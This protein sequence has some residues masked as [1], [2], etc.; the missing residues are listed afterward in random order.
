MATM[1]QERMSEIAAQLQ[2][3]AS[4]RAK[5]AAITEVKDMLEIVHTADCDAFLRTLLPPICGLLASVPALVSPTGG[6]VPA[7]APAGP[8]AGGADASS[9]PDERYVGHWIR[10]L[11]LEILHRIPTSSE[12]LKL[13]IGDILRSCC[14]A[15]A[16]D[17]EVNGL[18]AVR[19]VF[20]LH[21]NFRPDDPSFA[22]QFLQWTAQAYREFHAAYTHHESIV[23]EGGAATARASRERAPTDLVA[24]AK[25]TRV[26]S[27]C[28]VIIMFFHQLYK[29]LQTPIRDSARIFL[30][31]VCLRVPA[32]QRPDA[33]PQSEHVAA[34]FKGVQV[35]TLSFLTF[36]LKQYPAMFAERHKDI[37]D[38]VVYMLETCPDSIQVRKE[39]LIA[40]RHIVN[41][42]GSPGLHAS[43]FPHVATLMKE[44]TLL[45]CFAKELPHATSSGL[46]PLAYSLLAEI[47]HYM[48]E[49][50]TFDMIVANICLFEG[51]VHT[52][53]MTISI[54][55]TCIR[56]LLN[57]VQTLFHLRQPGATDPEAQRR[58]TRGREL[59][60]SVFKCYLGRMSALAQRTPALLDEARKER[61]VGGAI[62]ARLQKD[63]E[64][65]VKPWVLKRKPAGAGPAGG[66]GDGAGPGSTTDVKMDEGG[67]AGPEQ[68][69]APAQAA[70]EAC[71][72]T[73]GDAAPPA[74]RA[75]TDEGPAEAPPAADDAGSAPAQAPDPQLA[76][77]E[78]APYTYDVT[79]EPLHLHMQPPSDRLRELKDSK[80][81]LNVLMQSSRTIVFVLLHYETPK[82]APGAAPEPPGPRDPARDRAL[83]HMLRRLLRLA[84]KSFPLMWES[85]PQVSASQLHDR[86]V[87][88]VSVLP[89]QHFLDVFSGIA[90]DLFDAFMSCDRALHLALQLATHEQ[91]DVC[92]SFADIF[93]GYLL[94]NKLDKLGGGEGKDADKTRA[95][96]KPDDAPAA[97]GE[98]GPERDGN[99]GNRD[100]EPANK[101]QDDSDAARKP[102][103]ARPAPTESERVLRLFHLMFGAMKH[104]GGLIH[105]VLVPRLPMLVRAC[106]AAI[107]HHPDPSGHLELLRSCFK[108]LQPRPYE[109]V[110]AVLE[111]MLPE[112]IGTF[113]LMLDTPP[114][115]FSREQIVELML[116]IPVPLATLVPYLGTLVRPLMAALKS[117]EDG[118]LTQGLKALELWIDNVNPDYLDPQMVP[119]HAELVTTLHQML[120]PGQVNFS[121][122]A[123][124]ILGKLGGRNRR[125]CG[126]PY[127]L[128]YRKYP[129]HGLRLILCLEPQTSFLFPLDRCMHLA[130]QAITKAP[131]P[132]TSPRIPGRSAHQR[133][134]AARF[135]RACMARVLNLQDPAE[136]SLPGEPVDK[137]RDAL[138]GDF[139]APQLPDGI[140][141]SNMGVKTK[142]Q[143]GAEMNTVLQALAALLIAAAD[144]ELRDET[145]PFLRG[146]AR[147]VAL[148]FVSC[149]VHDKQG[150]GFRNDPRVAEEP[151]QAVIRLCEI[152]PSI[153]LEALAVQLGSADKAR[154][155]VALECVDVF[156]ASLLTFQAATKEH[157]LPKEAG[158][159]EGDAQGGDPMDVDATSPADKSAKAP[160]GGGGASSGA[161]AV[162]PS[163]H[164]FGPAL[165]CLL[166]EINK[167]LH[168]SEP[169]VLMGGVDALSVVCSHALPRHVL[170]EWVCRTLRALFGAIEHLPSIATAE[171][172]AVRATVRRWLGVCIGARV[173]EWRPVSAIVREA[174]R[175]AGTAY[176]VLGFATSAVGEAYAGDDAATPDEQTM[177]VDGG[178]V[179]SPGDAAGAPAEVD[180]PANVQEELMKTL[181]FVCLPRN[182]MRALYSQHVQL[183]GMEALTGLAAALGTTVQDL[184]GRTQTGQPARSKDAGDKDGGRAD[185]RSLHD[186][187]GSILNRLVG[188]GLLAQ[189]GRV[190]SVW[191]C[192]EVSPMLLGAEQATPLLHFLSEVL[193]LLEAPDSLH[194]QREDL[195]FTQA[196]L[197]DGPITQLRAACLR[198]L[199]PLLEKISEPELAPLRAALQSPAPPP[200]APPAQHL[201]SRD[202]AARPLDQ[203]I[204]ITLLHHLSS[205]KPLEAAA[206]RTAVRH[207]NKLGLGRDSM[208]HALEL[209]LNP[210]G[211]HRTLSLPLLRGMAH[212]LEVFP[213]WF[214][215]KLG[216]KLLDHLEKWMHPEKL[217]D[218]PHARGPVQDP[219][220]QQVP[221]KAW[222]TG[223]ETAVGVALVDLFHRLPGEQAAALLQSA[224]SRCGLVV[225]LIQVEQALNRQGLHIPSEEPSPYRRPLI[226]FLARHHKEALE[227][228]LNPRRLHDPT[229]FRLLVEIAR[230]PNGKGFLEHLAAHPKQLLVATGL[231]EA[232]PGD[233]ERGAGRASSSAHLDGSAAAAAAAGS[234]GVSGWSGPPGSKEQ[235]AQ[236]PGALLASAP[237]DM[238]PPSAAQLPVVRANGVRLITCIAQQK[239]GWLPAHP[240]VLAALMQRWEGADIQS[241]LVRSHDADLMGPG[242]VPSFLS[243]LTVQE[244]RGIAK[245]MVNVLR[246]R[247]ADPDGHV[248][249]LARL[250]HVVCPGSFAFV[251]T[252]VSE[253]IPGT[254]PVESL[255]QVVESFTATFRNVVAPLHAASARG[256]LPA[257]Q[258]EEYRQRELHMSIVLDKVV[259][260]IVHK[261]VERGVLDQ[262]FTDSCIQHLLSHVLAVDSADGAATP[263]SAA[264]Q[265]T[266]PVVP[267]APRSPSGADSYSDGLMVSLLELERLVMQHLG[268]RVYDYRKELIKLCWNHLKREDCLVKY[269]AFHTVAQFLAVID[270]PEKV[271]LQVF[272]ALLRAAQ[273][274]GRAYV[275]RATDVLLPRLRR[276][277]DRAVRER[278]ADGGPSESGGGDDATGARSGGERAAQYPMWVRWTKRIVLEEGH[279]LPSMIHVWQLVVRHSDLYY[280]AR[281][282]FSPM[283]VNSLS[284]LGLPTNSPIENRKLAID[285]AGVFIHWET[286]HRREVAAQRE[287]G[288]AEGEV[289]AK[290]FK[291]DVEA[292]M[293]SMVVNFLLRMCFLAMSDFVQR[294]EGKKEYQIMYHHTLALLTRALQLW[295]NTNV[296]MTYLE[297][298]L[299]NDLE[300]SYKDDD[301][302]AQVAP[303]QMAALDILLRLV[304]IAGAT[305][306]YA[307]AEQLAYLLRFTISNTR[308]EAVVDKLCDVLRLVFHHIDVPQL[309]Q[310]PQG[311][312][313]VKGIKEMLAV[314][315]Q[316]AQRTLEK[317]IHNTE[318][319]GIKAQLEANF[320]NC[321]NAVKVMEVLNDAHMESAQNILPMLLKL[322]N[323]IARE[324]VRP[325]VEPTPAGCEPFQAIRGR[326]NDVSY[327]YGT[328]VWL[329]VRG[330]R[331]ARRRI[332]V[333]HDEEKKRTFVHAMVLLITDHQGSNHHVHRAI[334][335]EL[336]SV[337]EFWLSREDPEAGC[338]SA[339][340]VIG[341]LQRV[342]T[343]D[344]TYHVSTALEKEWE[345]H[346]LA[347]LYR[348]MTD[349]AIPMSDA[350]RTEAMNKVERTYMCGLKAR[351]PAVRAKFFAIYDRLVSPDLF[352]RLSFIVSH[353][354]WEALASSFWLVNGLELLLSR[355]CLSDPVTIVPN[356]GL[357]APLIPG[358]TI[359]QHLP[360]HQRQQQQQQQAQQ[361]QQAQGQQGTGATAQPAAAA[362]QDGG[363][364]EGDAP[365]DAKPDGA[366]P[367]SKAEG[368]APGVDGDGDTRMQGEGPRSQAANASGAGAAGSAQ[369]TSGEAPAPVPQGRPAAVALE[370]LPPDVKTS[371]EEHA[372]FLQAQSGGTVRDVMDALRGMAVEDACVAHHLW[373]LVFPIV[374]ASLSKE[375]QTQLARPIM[376]L[377]SKE[378]HQRQAT[379]R[380]NVIQALLEGISLSLP[381][382][383][384]SAEL[385]R[386]LGKTFN[387]WPIA[388]SLLE[389]QITLFAK[390]ARSI[391]ALADLYRALSDED[392]LLGMWRRRARWP[393]TKPALSLIQLGLWDDAQELLVTNVLSFQRSKCVV[394]YQRR[395]PDGSVGVETH[396]PSKGELC[397]WI[398]QWVNTCRQLNQWDALREFGQAT[399][400]AAILLDTLWKM[401][402]WDMLRTY[403]SRSSIED[404]PTSMIVRGYLKIAHPLAPQ[405]LQGAEQLIQ[406]ALHQILVK[407][408]QL[409]EAGINTHTPLL[410][411]FQQLV[412]LLESK[413][414]LKDLLAVQ[415]KGEPDK[416]VDLNDLKASLDT[417]T[418]RL[419]NEWDSLPHW[420]DVLMW[421]NHVYNHVISTFDHLQHQPQTT[422]IPQ[423]E[424]FKMSTQGYRDKAWTVNRLASVARKQSSVR[425]CVDIANNLY[426]YSTM[427]VYEAY[428]KIRE[429]ARA[430]LSDPQEVITGYNLISSTNLD[431][432]HP[433]T[434][435]ELFRLKALLLCRMNAPSEA[436]Q[437]FTT[438]MTLNP[439]LPNG[440]LTWGQY[441][442]TMFLQGSQECGGTTNWLNSTVVCLLS[443]LKAGT[444]GAAL[445][446]PRVLKLLSAHSTIGSS[447]PT[448]IQGAPTTQ[449]VVQF[450]SQ[451][452]EQFLPEIPAWVWLSWLPQILVSLHLPEAQLAR[453]ILMHLGKAHPQATYLP[454]RSHL[455]GLREVLSKMT[456]E[457]KETSGATG[458]ASAGG[459]GGEDSGSG[460]TGD[461]AGEAD[462]LRQHQQAFAYGKEAMELARSCQTQIATLEFLATEIPTHFSPLQQERLHSVVHALLQ[463]CYR[464]QLPEDQAP[465]QSLLNEIHKVMSATS[466]ALFS[467]SAVNMRYKQQFMRDLDPMSE[468]FPKTLG[469][470]TSTLKSWQKLMLHNIE[471][472]IPQTMQLHTA[473][474]G[475]QEIN[476]ID[477]E[478][479]GRQ[480]L[481]GDPGKGRAPT[482][483][484]FGQVV[485][486]VRR[487]GSSYRRL[488]VHMTDGRKVHLLV[489]HFPNGLT[490]SSEEYMLQVMMVINRH[491][492]SMPQA[493]KRHLGYHIPIQAP[494][495]QHMRLIE[496]DPSFCL[497]GDAY[498]LH[499]LRRGLDCDQ[500]ITSFKKV[501]F[502]AEK[503]IEQRNEQRPEAERDDASTRRQ[504][505]ELAAFK[506]ASQLVNENIFGQFVY[507][508]LPIASQMYVFKQA[509]CGQMALSYL[510]CFMM[511]IGQR[512]PYRIL[513]SC[514]SGRVLNI[515][516]APQYERG[517]AEREPVP[518]R[519]TRNLQ[520]F[521]TVFGMEGPLLVSLVLAA[522]AALHPR[523][524]L[525][526]LLHL[527]YRGDL[528]NQTME[529]MT[530][531]QQSRQSA[532]E[533]EA[534]PG[535][536]R[537]RALP[538]EE[539]SRVVQSNCSS[540]M[541]RARGI[542]PQHLLHRL[543]SSQGC[544]STHEI[545]QNL[546]PVP[547]REPREE[548]NQQDFYTDPHKPAWD[549]VRRAQ[550]PTY[551][552]R[553][554]PPW[555]PFF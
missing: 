296:K 414:L 279:S 118:L 214:S 231:A 101:A 254:W 360:R 363:A 73:P 180:L 126:E 230:S 122:K 55:S 480:A 159:A 43:F 60:Q 456:R 455:V 412:E 517:V 227:Y 32:G 223:E 393:N 306:V 258:R 511:S 50:L 28:P 489:Q 203:R 312:L 400:Q 267:G 411:V 514:S 443:A 233:A 162:D 133:R 111:P 433:E 96:G 439:R 328:A 147:H 419:P 317:F 62:R 4:P 30:D 2:G 458:G 175:G 49:E 12:A 200:E 348:V 408:W 493:R 137:L 343:L 78:S 315:I 26:L 170:H 59:I 333:G 339:K 208:H 86:F 249:E 278:R 144:P 394:R 508:C 163:T 53:T 432:F 77:D 151:N 171:A 264:T 21:K 327:Q 215:P 467:T 58:H 446:V 76:S 428:I 405:S 207:L 39:L 34:D 222:R 152:P 491:L 524:C 471:N 195:P 367:A 191:F 89:P 457:R 318:Q 381:Q 300:K 353:Q 94:H 88:L 272:V 11:A 145:W 197:L 181:S 388:I 468:Q 452:T 263:A 234:P 486:V 17:N 193:L 505:A 100:S 128:D 130:Y 472:Y 45:G 529:R 460:G 245:C 384:I 82:H 492:E 447:L 435:A 533:G 426:K 329:Y 56:L 213:H 149:E 373:V 127:A 399:D 479:P 194:A 483:A 504:Q 487:N 68:P 398:E 206:A 295:P 551:L 380:P 186:F 79:E 496:D 253:E 546:K 70:A 370:D 259:L 188:R 20:D 397:L 391:E 138:F 212:L 268:Q 518:F 445:M 325:F 187:V 85:E 423:N 386:F 365:A 178:A 161:G 407:W 549:L 544:R 337:V 210:L 57:L 176:G 266:A 286:R 323:Y 523:S 382:P 158:D 369:Q 464:I 377:L 425:A 522:T 216:V 173:P 532:R 220:M 123:L 142:V 534:P 75:R 125:V 392:L 309:A 80:T 543:E 113:E 81:L 324:H 536:R 16:N 148:L 444:P 150:C 209:V 71:G 528:I 87:D 361:A 99:K 552:A 274:D 402:S 276:L 229:Y 308:S 520:T 420:N 395:K 236:H 91:N 297:K 418:L 54:Q 484:R 298:L 110:V 261:G 3:E 285:I 434:Q 548:N 354:D 69:A 542:A 260:P 437:A 115:R 461:G 320:S 281:Y 450:V 410:Q 251:E 167:M 431:Y 332:L 169:C 277:E 247:R 103:A 244:V 135:V 374:W 107:V 196:Q 416:P 387:A 269:Q 512:T 172:A 547:P 474:R 303:N 485:D 270:T 131:L 336:M 379:A 289:R 219:M 190:T 226:K 538:L 19:I 154:R 29:N 225:V 228:F 241:L 338:L 265:D 356:S 310:H 67:E 42:K 302:R 246:H 497:F 129:D 108:V 378:Y 430:Q 6:A 344:R 10:S 406:Q 95:D 442:Y 335:F 256:G 14:D 316:N 92:Q 5:L 478:L 507:K 403:L 38:A 136:S 262:I 371:L 192:L 199:A 141:A 459:D 506:R 283:M 146:L 98:K 349:D 37:C 198:L 185:K 375:Q 372:A 519:L 293:S 63:A 540:S 401:G 368:A 477:L 248:I 362:A 252:L 346:F 140:S 33:T 102:G 376:A 18:M 453:R 179:A 451:M 90:A 383:K 46:L 441:C 334:L 530:R 313:V 476:L 550:D 84:L 164:P 124:Q 305:G 205:H 112:I 250:L 156:L 307:V 242:G 364:A 510:M 139:G 429:Q 513:I 255:T 314:A 454:T 358:T 271:G 157:G 13:H 322:L 473:S 525:D 509:L 48:R 498:D 166:A 537:P 120:Q 134:Q 257:E 7:A 132:F 345:K 475:L 357:L 280:E 465:P 299:R 291:P 347:L 31:A 553:M 515:D 448:T 160:R 238:Q 288:A 359:A 235:S 239:P 184:M 422:T 545:E 47:V 470:L 331:A 438:A 554:D 330:L 114:R 61:E 104:R 340:E 449:Q 287:G 500:T 436:M 294:S 427:D 8:G 117:R 350:L 282:H 481:M 15:L 516:F 440:W 153:F 341:F 531:P 352:S 463:R 424:S 174:T 366:A 290:S 404:S 319:P 22:L 204:A 121:A 51:H 409:P 105:P 52:L 116:A 165:G 155:K 97:E 202:A 385:I 119:H 83:V 355:L 168:S 273:S 9:G 539:I 555:H 24:A 501:R 72:D 275:R 201:V 237:A 526:D 415:G 351:N 217:Q 292:G 41:D 74:K 321:C 23:A 469:E 232:A 413:T 284:R 421:R 177:D 189:I 40:T 521:F 482:V 36:L 27:E 541:N 535:P 1:T 389:A 109:G 35:K 502:E 243:D 390:E 240:E 494:I 417:W 224:D 503:A 65:S 221:P 182:A 304:G 326:E 106:L 64:L 218:M 66:G 488:T 396:Q 495:Q 93:L 143:L 211:S 499:F 311:Y 25:S 183:C 44:T 342:A 462:S 490:A 466:V 527:V 301:A